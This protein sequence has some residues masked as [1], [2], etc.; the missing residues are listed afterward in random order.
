MVFLLA[1]PVEMA[2]Q[3]VLMDLIVTVQAV[4]NPIE[5]GQEV[6]IAG[7]VVDHAGKPISEAE[8][9]IRI[10]KEYV[11][12]HTDETGNFRYEFGAWTGNPGRYS[13]NAIVTDKN[14]RIGIA[15]GDLHVRGSI[16]LT[17]QT[18]YSLGLFDK[19]RFENIDPSEFQNDPISITLYNY[20]QGLKQ[21]LQQEELRQKLLEEKQIYLEMQRN[22]ATQMLQRAIEEEKPGAGTYT[23][24][25]YD[26]FVSNLNP[27]IKEI[28]VNQLNYTVNTF[29]EAQQAMEEVLRQGGTM[30]DARKAYNEKAS[31]PREIMERLTYTS[32]ESEAINQTD[33]D[34]IIEQQTEL[35]PDNNL[36]AEAH[37]ASAFELSTNG[38]TISVAENVTTIFLNV[39]GSIIELKINGTQI[40]LLTNYN[41]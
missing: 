19:S 33:S 10:D 9:K 6:V 16:S 26:V 41:N 32:F 27:S 24:W 21:K 1:S 13:V 28:I 5:V 2:Y 30:E 39:N 14:E 29:N 18:S 36:T 8:V 15:N 4:N 20:Y 7:T 12:T 31:V 40:R 11:I 37:T 23:G 22:L 34:Y 3:A 17:D 35:E 38:A 25:K